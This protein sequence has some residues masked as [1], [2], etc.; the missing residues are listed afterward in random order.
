MTHKHT[1][2]ILIICIISFA[3]SKKLSED[4]LSTGKE[5]LDELLEKSGSASKKGLIDISG[6]DFEV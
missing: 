5:K 2:W 4:V 3:F 6:S 1:L